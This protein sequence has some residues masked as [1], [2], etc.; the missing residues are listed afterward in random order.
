MTARLKSWL[1]HGLSLVL[2]AL[3]LY[4]A[5]RDV[6]FRRMG[7]TLATANYWWLIPFVG[8]A[9]GSHLLRAWRWLLLLE[10]LPAAKEREA[11]PSLWISFS[12][13][14][15]G[16]MVNY[17]APRAGEVARAGNM[18]VQEQF[19]F[20][21]VLGTVVAERVLDILT[22]G[23]FFLTLPIFLWEQLDA[24]NN[25]LVDLMT[26]VN[27][28]PWLSVFAIGGALIALSGLGW[29]LMRR[30]D[31]AWHDR[32]RPL[33]QSFAEGFMTLRRCP[34][35]FALLASTLCIW[36]C[37][38]LM[39]YVPLLV[40]NMAGPYDLSLVD[41]WSIF[42]LGS[43]GMLVPLPGGLGS[44][45][46]ITKKTLQR[47]FSVPTS[48]ATTYAVFTH[49]AQL[50]LYTLTGLLCLLIQGTGLQ[51]LRERTQQVRTEAEPSSP[52]SPSAE[53]TSSHA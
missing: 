6:D 50:V 36:G 16:Y 51:A 29:W 15:I 46:L 26:R 24:L 5:L 37:Y 42:L 22:V 9:L 33:L 4:L 27:D 2:A 30:A 38:F 48:P 8:L 23:I 28:L 49:A 39:A 32:V 31:V 3:L 14:M 20:S 7:R 43:L 41:T 18:A 21:S 53:P 45:H 34:H 10:M 44:Y 13:V 19:R 47:L 11:R 35:R 25:M 17:A 40:L 12:S 1:V 52:D